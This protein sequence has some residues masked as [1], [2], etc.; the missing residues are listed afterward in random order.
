MPDFDPAE[1][2]RETYELAYERVVLAR[3]KWVEAGRPL[4]L[5]QS[6]HVVGIHP[7]WKALREA[8]QD[9]SKYLELARVKHRGPQPKAVVQTSIGESPAAKLRSVK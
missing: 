9:S 5:E 7:L 4:T 1:R 2:A 6:N 3:S 8:E